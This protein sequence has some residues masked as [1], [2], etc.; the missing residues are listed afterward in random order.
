M[1]ESLERIHEIVLSQVPRVLGLGD[2]D[3]SSETFGCFDRGYWHY[4]SIDFPNTR[5]QEACWLLA[6]LYQGNFDGNIYYQ[7]GQVK[8]WAEAAIEFWISRRH[9]DGSVDEAYPNERGFCATAFTCWAVTEAMLLLRRSDGERLEKTGKWLMRH[10]NPDVSNQMAA[11]ACALLNLYHLTSNTPYLRASEEKLS[12]LLS[13]QESSGYF[14]EYG[15]A[16]VGYL[17]LIVGCLAH[18]WKR[19][20][21]PVL[22]ESLKRALGFLEER[23]DEKGH[24][25]HHRMS[26]KTQFLYSYGVAFFGSPVFER[27]CR[28]LEEGTLL[29][30]VWL[31]DRYF[32]PLTTDYLETVLWALSERHAVGA[33]V[34]S[35]ESKE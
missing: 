29:N 27:I 34:E 11:A 20:K 1:K 3:P 4:K 10:N 26:R 13:S 24:Y 25:D 30:P 32:M 35:Y 18:Y 14:P 6:L 21:D 31:D 7:N 15:G 12:R 28:G 5:Y 2:R 19:T 33:A 8:Q 9:R 22:L 23:I 17:S 16:D